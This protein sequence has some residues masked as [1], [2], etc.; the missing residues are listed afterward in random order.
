MVCAALLSYDFSPVGYWS[1]RHHSTRSH[2]LQPGFTIVNCCR[3][4]P[5]R[6]TLARL[7]TGGPFFGGRAWALLTFAKQIVKFLK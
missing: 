3:A 2:I 5:T 6:F 7:H 1:G 4:L